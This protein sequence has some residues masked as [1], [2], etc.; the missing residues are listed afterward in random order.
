LALMGNVG[1]PGRRGI[2]YERHVCGTI[3]ACHSRE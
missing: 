3:G 1:N 2:F